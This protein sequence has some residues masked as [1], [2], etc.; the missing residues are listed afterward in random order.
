MKNWLKILAIKTVATFAQTLGALLMASGSAFNVLH[1]SW[2][3][4]LGIALG[5]ALL[6]ILMHIGE[7]TTTKD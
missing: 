2:N 1:T 6:C 5:A 3:E 4:N 7:L